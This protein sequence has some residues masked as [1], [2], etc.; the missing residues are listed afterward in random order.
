MGFLYLCSY[1]WCIGNNNCFD[2]LECVWIISIVWGFYGCGLVFLICLCFVVKGGKYLW[3]FD[4]DDCWF[5]DE[6]F[7]WRLSFWYLSCY[8]LFIF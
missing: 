4:G 6:N 3:K 5:V 8:L 1:C 7:W 2:G